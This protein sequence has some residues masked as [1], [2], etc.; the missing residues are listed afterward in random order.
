MA[1][2]GSRQHDA[3]H[4]YNLCPSC[5]QLW[6]TDWM[7]R[8]SVGICPICEAPVV[9][10]IGQDPWHNDAKFLGPRRAPAS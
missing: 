8:R 4:R 9:P 5:E 6:R 2:D 7:R 1:G 10:Y 3:V